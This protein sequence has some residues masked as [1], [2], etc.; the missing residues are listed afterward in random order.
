LTSIFGWTFIS[1]TISAR[2]LSSPNNIT[3]CHGYTN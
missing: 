1:A 3:G 2:M